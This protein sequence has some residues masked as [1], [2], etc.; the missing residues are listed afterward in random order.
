MKAG[1]LTGIEDIKAEGKGQERCNLLDKF[2][3]LGLH[4]QQRNTV[5]HVLKANFLTIMALS[6]EFK[7]SFVIPQGIKLDGKSSDYPTNT[8]DYINK[9]FGRR[10]GYKCFYECL[11][12]FVVNYLIYIAQ[13]IR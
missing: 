8:I 7:T 13:R 4:Q 5:N 11:I 1:M 10:M 6:N 3:C 2:Y 12:Y 9:L